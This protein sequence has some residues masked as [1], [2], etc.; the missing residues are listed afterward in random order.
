MA[1]NARAVYTDAKEFGTISDNQG[2]IIGDVS[3]YPN[4]IGSNFVQVDIDLMLNLIQDLRP[5]FITRASHY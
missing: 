2:V 5:M 1:D 4:I 3:G